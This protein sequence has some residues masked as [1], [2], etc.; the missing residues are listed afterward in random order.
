MRDTRKIRKKKL[1]IGVEKRQNGKKMKIGE[2]GK[3]KKRMKK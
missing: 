2:N 3:N 1:K